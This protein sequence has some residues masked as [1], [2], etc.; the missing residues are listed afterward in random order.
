MKPLSCM[1]LLLLSIQISVWAQQETQN[2][3]KVA[4]SDDS[5]ISVGRL[6]YT[7]LQNSG[8]QMAINVT[9]MRTSIANVNYGDAAI[10][11]SQTDGL[12]LQFPNLVKVPFPIDFVEF[13]AYTRSNDSYNLS[14]WEDLKGLRLCYRWQNIYVANQSG[15]TGASQIISVNELQEVW[16]KL[17]NNEADV[18]IL[19]RVINFDFRI[20]HGIKK[21]DVIDSIPCFTYVNKEYE[22]L[23]PLLEKAYKE[24][25]GDVSLEA[26][27]K[28]HLSS[29]EP[30][31][32]QVILHISS[33]N[34]KVERERSQAEVVRQTLESNEDVEY[35]NLNLN[36]YEHR[37]N[38]SF[39]DIYSDMIRANYITQNI[40][41]IITSNNEALKFV[42]DHYFI[43]FS[44]IPVV[45][46]GVNNLDTS[47][48]YSLKEFVTGIS[49]SISFEET[50]REMLR[51]YPKTKQIFILNDYSLSRSINMRKDIE[52]RIETYK[53][54]VEFIFSEDKPFED[55]IEEIR[56]FGSD[57]LILIGNYLVDSNDIFY[58]EIDVQKHVSSASMNPIFCLT[59]TYMGY[60]TFGGLVSAPEVKSRIAVSMAIDILNGKKVSDIP[61]IFDST[62]FH[63]WQFDYKTANRFKINTNNLPAGHI[64]INRVLHVWESNPLE[65]NLTI[66]VIIL[67]LFSICT[68]IVFLKI[69]SKKQAE[70]QSATNAKSAFLAN[71]S[72]EIRTP[73]N[74]I[75]GMASVGISADNL[76]R[77][78]YCFKRI[79]EASK[80]L[81]GV[82]N[83]ILDM[84][85]IEANKLELTYTDI[86]FKEMI[87]RIIN[88]N[89]VNLNE[90]NQI[91]T[92]H[93]D[94]A[95]PQ[96]IFCDEQRL[97]QVITNLIGNAV[98]FTPEKGSITL[99]TE[100]LAKENDICTIKFSVIDTGIGISRD[101]Q[102]NL[103]QPFHQAETSTSR[104]F[105]GTGLGLSISKNIIEMM[106][107]RIWV[108][109]ELGKGASFFFTIQAKRSDE[110]AQTE[111]GE[112]PSDIAM[113]FSG[114]CI[115]LVED[116]EI[117][118]EIVQALLEPTQIT[119]DCAENGKE[120]VKM[121][122]QAP[123]KYKMIFMDVQ[124]PLMDGYETTR[125]IRALNIPRAK[126]IPIVAMT[127]NVFR[128]DIEKCLASGMNSHIG[129]PL[130][131]DEVMGKL[132]LYMR[133]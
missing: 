10:L 111:N 99:H 38:A 118:R 50:T 26:I 19:P 86:N 88:V 83:D 113:Q 129:K 122:I 115:L 44:N 55:I 25:L 127:A 74:A 105:G 42:M 102:V 72:H 33:Y 77:K 30:G 131:F 76:E 85:K 108:E 22:Y 31:S 62:S 15:R 126:T 96:F 37:Y 59:S 130:N 117:N 78:D 9:G 39:N 116:L 75:V 79:N 18:T 124:M 104:E 95:I 101:K 65:F 52:R 34:E 71:M 91:L 3:I 32:K 12:Q 82:I 63:R 57:T 92:V 14:S 7:A 17:L 87:Q 119:I 6:L 109:S 132:C 11:P 103:F 125:V 58:S 120:A 98:K 73:M 20:P 23:V 106:G 54:P 60:G 93:I 110:T 4:M 5:P 8:Y 13:T 64:V 49:S 56:N 67:L 45:F 43:L 84:S 61:V 107:G 1:I 27:R 35:K 94:P 29:K 28:F 70:A 41:L 112:K 53:F 90:K 114:H 121:F 89:N 128:D 48:L 24:M 69:L 2:I 66:V 47:E 51:L 21:A 133:K 80:H 16:E 68:L 81:L 46:C 100:L 97:S 123:D 36:S 40:G